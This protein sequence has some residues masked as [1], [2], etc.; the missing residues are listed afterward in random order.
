[1]KTIKNRDE[2]RRVSDRTAEELVD[3][4]WKYCPKSEFKQKVSK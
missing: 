4:G 3:K 1:M 2:V